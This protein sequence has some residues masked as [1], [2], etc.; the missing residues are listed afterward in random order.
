MWTLGWTQLLSIE[1]LVYCDI[2]FDVPSTFEINKSLVG[3]THLRVIQFQLFREPWHLS[4]K[5]FLLLLGPYDVHFTL[6][7]QYKDLLIGFHV[8]VIPAH[9]PPLKQQAKLRAGL[10]KVTF[11]CWLGHRYMHMVIARL[12]TYQGNNIVVVRRQELYFLHDMVRYHPIHL[13]HVLADFI[14]H[15]G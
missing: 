1:K 9:L 13:G 7:Q 5:E 11:Q 6:T 3:F 8:K 2:T 14:V 10:T 4:Y 12:I 15:K